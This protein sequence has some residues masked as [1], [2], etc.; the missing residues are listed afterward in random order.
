[1]DDQ[2]IMENI[3]WTAFSHDERHAAISDIQA[4]IARHGYLIDVHLFSDLSLSMTIE[5][6]ERKIDRLHEELKPILRVEKH[7]YLNSVSTRERILYL[8]IT[9]ARGTGDLKREVPF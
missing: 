9:F 5:L 1:M 3:F 2:Q 4:A 6:E 8:N 7:E